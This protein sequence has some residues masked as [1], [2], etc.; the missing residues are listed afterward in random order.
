LT[1]LWVLDRLAGQLQTL[2]GVRVQIA[3]ELVTRIRQLTERIN[4]LE[5]DLAR[6]VEPLAGQLREIVKASG[7]LL[8]AAIR[9]ATSAWAGW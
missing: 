5:A 7:L 3:A 2:A 4:Q 9:R 6:R 8:P 1:R